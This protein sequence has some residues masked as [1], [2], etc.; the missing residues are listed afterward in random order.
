MRVPRFAQG[1]TCQSL[2]NLPC[3]QLLPELSISLDYFCGD[4]GPYELKCDGYG[5][6]WRRSSFRKT[7]DLAENWYPPC[8]TSESQSLAVIRNEP[9]KLFSKIG[10][11]S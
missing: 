10:W 6:P 9:M 5:G 7:Y 11:V 4:F 3:N 8:N 2:V 1:N